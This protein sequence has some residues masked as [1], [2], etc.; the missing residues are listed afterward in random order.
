MSQAYYHLRSYFLHILFPILTN[1]LLQNIILVDFKLETR[2][3]WIFFIAM[4]RLVSFK[5]EEKVDHFVNKRFSQI[6]TRIFLQFFENT[7]TGDVQIRQN[8]IN[9]VYN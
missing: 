7:I 5:F 2:R 6:F 1:N 8:C 9:W 3:F 4:K